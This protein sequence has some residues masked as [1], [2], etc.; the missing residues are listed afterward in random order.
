ME[1]LVFSAGVP[2]KELLDDG[3]RTKYIS[4]RDMMMGNKQKLTTR[5]KMDLLKENLAKIELED[6][7]RLKP[8]VHVAQAVYDGLCVP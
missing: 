2:G 5:P 8:K 3:G 1:T 4:S 7:N 6:G